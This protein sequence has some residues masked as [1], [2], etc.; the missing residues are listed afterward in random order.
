MVLEYI[1]AL[2]GAG[3]G[4]HKCTIRRPRHGGRH[5]EMALAALVGQAQAVVVE[6]QLREGTN[7]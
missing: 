7:P 1:A 2:T 6:Q 4:E 3:A 5:E